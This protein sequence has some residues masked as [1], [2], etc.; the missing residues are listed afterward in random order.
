MDYLDHRLPGHHKASGKQLVPLPLYNDI[1]LPADKGFIDLQ[2]AL[3]HRGIRT[4]LI[5]RPQKHNVVQHD[6]LHR[7]FFQRSLSY[8]LD[9]SGSNQGQLVQCLLGPYF[10]KDS[11]AGVA[12]HNPHKKQILKRTHEDYK[13]G[14]NNIYQVKKRHEIVSDDLFYAFTVLILLLI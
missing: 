12:D 7:D 10:L 13:S 1:R 8:Y 11:N 4:D 14:Q 3:S 5:S 6:L 9:F 2:H